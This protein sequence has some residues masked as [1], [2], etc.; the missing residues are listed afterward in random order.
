MKNRIIRVLIGTS[1]AGLGIYDFRA[2]YVCGNRKKHTH[3]HCSWHGWCYVSLLFLPHLWYTFEHCIVIIFK[4]EK[5][6][7]ENYYDLSLVLFLS[8]N[9]TVK[10]K[11][12]IKNE[13]NS[14][15]LFGLIWMK[16]VSF[17]FYINVIAKIWMNMYFRSIEILGNIS[18][19]GK[20]SFSLS[21]E[22]WFYLVSNHSHILCTFAHIASRMNAE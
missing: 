1:V 5:P 17:F 9:L 12:K 22:I 14:N 18:R 4:K 7:R 10:Q 16:V 2:R 11:K 13:L 19:V 6:V 8:S 20:S 15:W 21:S 3:T